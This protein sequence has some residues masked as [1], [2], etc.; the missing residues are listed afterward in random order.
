MGTR[1]ALSALALA[2]LVAFPAVAAPSFCTTPMRMIQILRGEHD[3]H[4]IFRWQMPTHSLV[5][6]YSEERKTMSVVTF[7]IHRACIIQ[8]REGVERVNE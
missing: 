3:E 4:P 2:A 7:Q 1:S 5:I 8:S 6:F